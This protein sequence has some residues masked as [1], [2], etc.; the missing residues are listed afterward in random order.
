VSVQPIA[1]LAE[2]QR[3][4]QAVRE[5]VWERLDRERA[6]LA[7]GA[8]GRIPNFR[9]AEVAAD[10]LAALPLW[11]AAMTVKANPDKAQ[12]AVRAR[13]LADG[14]QLYMA[15]PRL[16]DIRPFIAVDPANLTVTPW[17]AASKE[18]AAR[19]GRKVSVSELRPVDLVVC[20]SVVVNRDGARIGKGGGFSDIEVALL[21]E[22]GLLQPT[23]LLATTVHSLQVVGEQ[24][25]E[26]THDFRVDLVVTPEEVIWCPSR[27]RPPGI[28]W[29]HLD[30]DKLAAVP[31]LE[32]LRP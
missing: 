5:R 14:K 9:E 8:A 6:A 12:R 3:A 32:T 17:D 16:A 21:L 30:Q 26:T 4:K 25:P 28:L 31:V 15:V 2:I 10:R 29:E 27:P 20:G 18:G 1:A 13:A 24:L 23:T 19:W 7:P 11:Q 22:A